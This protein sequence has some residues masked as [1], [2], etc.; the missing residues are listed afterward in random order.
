M[1]T[2][3]EL[4]NQTQSRVESIGYARRVLDPNQQVKYSRSIEQLAENF[5][6]VMGEFRDAKRAE[7]NARNSAAWDHLAGQPVDLPIGTIIEFKHGP[8]NYQYILEVRGWRDT[9]NDMFL[10]QDVEDFDFNIVRPGYLGLD[11][12]EAK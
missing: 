8:I 7:Y 9:E 5:L 10:P 11:H 3:Q 2:K 1:T 6:S 4:T 12:P